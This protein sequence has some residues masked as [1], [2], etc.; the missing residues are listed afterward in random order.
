MSV[1]CFQV[2][3][4]KMLNATTPAAPIGVVVSPDFLEMDTLAEVRINYLDVYVVLVASTHCT[5]MQLQLCYH[6]IG[7]VCDVTA[8]YITFQNK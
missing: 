6:S 1:A 8:L 5:V 7:M 3:A 4:T 2:R